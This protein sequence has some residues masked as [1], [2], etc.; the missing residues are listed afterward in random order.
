[1]A[2]SLRTVGKQYI[3]NSQ[4]EDTAVSSYEV[5]NFDAGYRFEK[6]SG[7]RGMEVRLRVN[8][9]L[10]SEYETSGYSDYDD[11]T[12]RYFVAPPTNIFTTLIIDV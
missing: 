1:L 11:G 12:P 2:L 7:L 9:L 4:N 10:N 3:D 8:N 5:L 6:V